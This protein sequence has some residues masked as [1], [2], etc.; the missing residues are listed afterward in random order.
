[1]QVFFYLLTIV[2]QQFLT[3]GTNLWLRYW[4]GNNSETGTN[5]DL[6]FYLSIYA[7]FG[8]AASLVFL[9]NGLILYSF[10]V[11]RSAKHMHD[12]MFHAVMRSPMLF[13]GT[14]S[15]LVARLD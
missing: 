9:A 11:V 5:G 12:G 10:C 14:L 15:P 1:M 6:T 7:A 4:S 2:L 3:I 8:V 13:F